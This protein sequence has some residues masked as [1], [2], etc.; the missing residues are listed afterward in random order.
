MELEQTMDSTTR[1]RLLRFLEFPQGWNS[2]EMYPETFF[3]LQFSSV[4]EERGISE[5]EFMSIPEAETYG[6]GSE[7]FRAAVILHWLR[8]DRS[9]YE[10]ACLRDLLLSDPDQPMAKAFL[11]ELDVAYLQQF[12]L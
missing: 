7:H 2:G 1:E 8:K 6:L 10:T 3:E 4:L 9:I 5:H 12:D 11:K